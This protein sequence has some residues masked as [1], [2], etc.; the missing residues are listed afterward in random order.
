MSVELMK[1][2]PCSWTAPLSKKPRRDQQRPP[3]RV[4]SASYTVAATG[5]GRFH[6]R[7]AQRSP[8][9]P[10]PT[11]TTRGAPAPVAAAARFGVSSPP[12]S[13]AA[14]VSAPAAPRSRMAAERPRGRGGS[15]FFVV[16]ALVADGL[17]TDA[18]AADGLGALACDLL[19]GHAAPAR[20]GVQGEREADPVG[21]RRP[22]RPNGVGKQ[23]RCAGDACDPSSRNPGTRKP[24]SACGHGTRAEGE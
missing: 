22:G 13:A 21:Y 7:W 2:P 19:D 17:T 5:F 16:A 15:P 24:N 20:F 4:A 11:T 12:G 18:L 1:A 10:A 9:S 8:A 6:N 23:V 14:A 3:M